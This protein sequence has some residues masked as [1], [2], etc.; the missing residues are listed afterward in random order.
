MLAELRDLVVENARVI[1]FAE[2]KTEGSG[3]GLAV[4]MHSNS[5]TDAIALMALIELGGESSA[6]TAWRRRSWRA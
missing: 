6:T 1:H 4:L 5:Q 3:E 2:S